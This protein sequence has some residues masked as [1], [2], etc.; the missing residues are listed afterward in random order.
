MF[1]SKKSQNLLAL[2]QSFSIK[3]GKLYC[4]NAYVHVYA[5]YDLS[6]QGSKQHS[7]QLNGHTYFICMSCAEL[8]DVKQ[9][10]QDSKWKYMHPP[11]IAPANPRFPI[12]C[13]RPLDHRDIFLLRLKL[14][15]LLK[16]QQAA[17]PCTKSYQI[18]YGKKC[19]GTECQTKSAFLL[20]M[21][22]LFISL[23]KTFHED[24]KP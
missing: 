24:T 17:K 12:G 4:G 3:R 9:A 19:I 8:W 20:Q 22:M 7:L 6:Y 15:L 5:L 18:D 16:N 11:G 2:M 10:K 1:Q 23:K 21:H 14:V 13:L